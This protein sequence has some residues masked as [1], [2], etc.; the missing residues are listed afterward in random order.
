M[1]SSCAKSPVTPTE[2]KMV[3]ATSIPP[4]PSSAEV[5]DLKQCR[6]LVSSGKYAQALPLCEA[7]AKKYPKN[8]EAKYLEAYCLQMT[9]QRLD[10][11]VAL[12]DQA[13]KQ[14]FD[15]FWVS[16][17]RGLLYFSMGN[18]KKARN[19][20]KVAVATARD[21]GQAR[22]VQEFIDRNLKK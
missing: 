11:A 7:A 21:P 5:A 17:N 22:G 10:E 18:R 2:P 8:A 19:D 9:N 14:G 3:P 1:L 12:Y 6:D 16:Y 13:E 15:K 4:R 20:L